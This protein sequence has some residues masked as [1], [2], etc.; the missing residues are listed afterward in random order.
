MA[1]SSEEEE[2]VPE[3][4]NERRDTTFMDFLSPKARTEVLGAFAKVQGRPRNEEEDD[5]MSGDEEEDADHE[6]RREAIAVRVRKPATPKR[7]R[8][9]RTRK[10]APLVR[11]GAAKARKKTPTPAKARKRSPTMAKAKK[12]KGCECG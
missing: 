1:A 8:T 3:D 5:D 7:A 9:S 11:K 12:E 10:A 6:N 4:A 2:E